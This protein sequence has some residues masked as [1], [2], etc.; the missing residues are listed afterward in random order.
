MCKRGDGRYYTV[1]NPFDH[2]AFMAWADEADLHDVVEPFAGANH[3]IDHLKDAGY[4]FASASYDIEP[5]AKEVE[6]RDTIVEFPQGFSACVT[7]PPWLAKNSARARG[8]PFPDTGW[9]DL[10][11]VCLNLCL[12]HCEWV[13]AIV[14]ESFIRS[15]FRK[16]RLSDF[17]T[18]NTPL[19]TETE[20]PAGL[21]LF[22]PLHYVEERRLHHGLEYIGDL[23]H[24]LS[25]RL[26]PD[27][28]GQPVK[29]ADP[30][31]NV[32]LRAVDG[33]AGPSIRF[34][35]PY[36]IDASR[37]RPS[38]RFVTRLSVQREN[39]PR[40]NEVLNDLR[41]RTRD[42]ILS[43]TKGMRKDGMYRRRLDF[44]LAKGIIH[45]ER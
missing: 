21:A 3:L 26:Q 4:S 17:I 44:T 39:W 25:Y 10:Y 34:C 7:N 28:H 36:E 8:I 15:S 24:M 32:G 14:P 45:H 20:H 38:N 19:F 27:P 1:R 33:T 35:S 13:A 12:E 16:D 11:Q 29:F 37:V 40:W 43:A 30:K 23:Y 22:K 18:M 41:S 42:V 31:G 6:R 5:R 2:P 9:E